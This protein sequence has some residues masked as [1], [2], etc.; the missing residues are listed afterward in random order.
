MPETPERTALYRLFDTEGN[1]LYVGIAKNPKRRWYQHSVASSDVWWP[2]VHEK[3]VEWFGTRTEAEAAEKKAIRTEGPSYNTT[4]SPAVVHLPPGWQGAAPAPSIR[5]KAARHA[6]YQRGLHFSVQSRHAK[7]SM[8]ELVAAK[9]REDIEA[10]RYELGS[11]IPTV[12]ALAGQFGISSVT[13][14]RGLA[15]LKGQGVIESRP[16]QGTFVIANRS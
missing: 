3:R 10:G 16:G 1:L 7:S 5:A 9:I 6:S 4:H 12:L 15:L 14:S 2:D 13:V 8:P 11:R